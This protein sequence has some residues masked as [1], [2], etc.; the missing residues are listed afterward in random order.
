MGHFTAGEAELRSEVEEEVLYCAND[1]EHGAVNAARDFQWQGKHLFND[2]W[3]V[4]NRAYTFAF[5]WCCYA[6]SWAIQQYDAHH[7][8]RALSAARRAA[9][10]AGMAVA[11]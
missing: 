2:F 5:L 4:N 1:G 7:A 3:E 10:V 8:N 6:I 9:I 11:A